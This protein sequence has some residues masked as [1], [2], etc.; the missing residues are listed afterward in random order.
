[1]CGFVL[2][3]GLLPWTAHAQELPAGTIV[4]VRLQQP[5]SSFGSERDDRIT[6]TVIAPA[7]SDGQVLVP[8]GARILG[9]VEGVRRVGLGFSRETAST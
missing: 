8:L 4:H 1:M 2:V 6:T 9:H 5:V 3:A 7:I